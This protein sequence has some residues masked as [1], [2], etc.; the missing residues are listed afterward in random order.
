MDSSLRILRLM[1]M[2]P[3]GHILSQCPSAEGH[4]LAM[5]FL[6]EVVPLNIKTE[7]IKE[8]WWSLGRRHAR[9]A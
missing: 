5:G 9:V 3:A 1:R 7:E 4:A 2:L 8:V 6:E